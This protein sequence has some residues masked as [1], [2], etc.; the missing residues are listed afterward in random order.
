VPAIHIAFGPK[1]DE[2]RGKARGIIAIGDDAAGG[3]AIGGFARGIVAIG[4]AAIGVAAFG[5]AAVGL[6]TALGGFA[7]GAMAAGGGSV[8]AVA[9]GGGAVGIIADGGGTV[10]LYTRGGGGKRFASAARSEA[11]FQRWSWL[12][13]SRGV[14]SARPMLWAAGVP[15]ALAVVIGLLV[16][17]R[18]ATHRGEP[19][20][21]FR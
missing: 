21:G 12:L 19:D 11:V 7:L 2:L 20:T 8:G 17:F 1:G 13:G 15:V 14:S 9:H 5:G 6:L 16:L 4:G 3:I 18:Y 10:G